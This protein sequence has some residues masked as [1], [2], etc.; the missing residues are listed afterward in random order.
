MD[1]AQQPQPVRRKRWLDL[2]R[3]F[4]VP[5]LF[6]TGWYTF[7]AKDMDIGGG[8][9]LPLT[10]TVCRA[11]AMVLGLSDR[12]YIPAI[13]FVMVLIVIA[14]G[15]QMFRKQHSA[16]QFFFPAILILV[17]ALFLLIKKPQYLYFRYFVVVFPFFYLLL[18]LLL[19]RLMKYR[20][21]SLRYLA[22]LCA[23]LVVGGQVSRLIPLLV[24]GRGSYDRAIEYIIANSSAAPIRIGS[25]NDA[26]NH[27]LLNYYL[28]RNG[29]KRKTDYL[30]K[31]EWQTGKVL[32]EW[33]IFHCQDDP[34]PPP[35]QITPGPGLTYKLAGTF[36]S[37]P[38]S[39]F[40][41]HLYQKAE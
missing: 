4:L 11:A 2:P 17:P 6:F 13:A 26:R 39:G 22:V 27:M 5:A 16:L 1:I 31:E 25:D 8:P 36:P 3:F 15:T 28:A 24:T 40:T 12:G 35:Q 10:A 19:A 20:R 7:F 32:P 21:T 37:S 38:V 41:W 14:V 9:E 18:G 30:F 34:T 33:F 29:T 23:V